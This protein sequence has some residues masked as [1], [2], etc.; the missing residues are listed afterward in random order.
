MAR[1]TEAERAAM[2][3]TWTELRVQHQNSPAHRATARVIANRYTV[4]YDAW[5]NADQ[6]IERLFNRLVPLNQ[7][8]AKLLELD[9]RY[10]FRD[11][12]AQLP[13]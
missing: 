13:R 7:L 11:G 4:T 3:R 8:D 10:H 5:G 2:A 9:G 6:Q 12:R 1:W